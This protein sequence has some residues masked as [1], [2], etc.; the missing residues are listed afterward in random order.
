MIR[1]HDRSGKL[2]PVEKGSHLA[3]VSFALGTALTEGLSLDDRLS[4]N[5]LQIAL[6]QQDEAPGEGIALDWYNC[7]FRYAV[8][9]FPRLLPLSMVDHDVIT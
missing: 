8:Q 2:G 4:V 5:L 3:H 6:R 7:R 9:H 1:L